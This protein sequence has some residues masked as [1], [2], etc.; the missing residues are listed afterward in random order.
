MVNELT[1]E[2]YDRPPEQVERLKQ[3][4]ERQVRDIVRRLSRGGFLFVGPAHHRTG[5]ESAAMFEYAV[6]FV[7]DSGKSEF[8]K[9]KWLMG[10]PWF[11]LGRYPLAAL[12][13]LGYNADPAKVE[14]LARRLEEEAPRFNLFVREDGI[15]LD[16]RG[17]GIDSCIRK[18]QRRLNVSIRAEAGLQPPPDWIF[19]REFLPLDTFLLAFADRIA[20]KLTKEGDAYKISPLEISKPPKPEPWELVWQKAG[21]WPW[22]RPPVVADGKVILMMEHGSF[23]AL[24][25]RDG[26]EAW[27]T[28]LAY[29]PE[30]PIVVGE[31]LYIGGGDNDMHAVLVKDGKKL[32]DYQAFTPTEGSVRLNHDVTPIG[33][34]GEAALFAS[35]DENVYA[36]DRQKGTEL[37]KYKR[38]A[39]G[40][41][42]VDEGIL[43]YAGGGTTTA[44]N[45]VTRRV[46]WNTPVKITRPGFLLKHEDRI[47]VSGGGVVLAMSVKDGMALWQ[48]DTGRLGSMDAP[49]HVLGNRLLV[50]GGSDDNNVYG[51]D[52]RSGEILWQTNVPGF[53]FRAALH[54]E[55]RLIFTLNSG[56][57]YT[58]DAVTGNPLE[59]RPMDV[60]V[61]GGPVVIGDMILVPTRDR[62]AEGRYGRGV[63]SAYRP[64]LERN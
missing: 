38:P 11:R 25:L 61:H 45:V 24:S 47:L 29:S 52:V 30:A 55:R 35:T 40:P 14:A 58:L 64:G 28:R 4:G 22:L 31:T 19:I 51:L 21:P 59:D 57:L 15:R 48:R 33:A 1:V 62:Q 2:A 32:W 44:L 6:G 54:G 23:V 27:Q 46:L 60:T 39:R 7:R 8:E 12:A 26:A 3:E 34:C 16:A 17:V 18:F 49:M 56:R 37:W 50:P 5:G 41:C 10:L 63:L 36:I 43:Y 42:W 53:P 13:A 9:A 20:A